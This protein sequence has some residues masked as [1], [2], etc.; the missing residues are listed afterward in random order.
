MA[1]FNRNQVGENGLAKIAEDLSLVRLKSTD[2]IGSI[3]QIEGLQDAL[4]GK[5][6]STHTHKYAG[7]ASAGG[8]ATS[9]NKV[10][11]SLKIQ[12]NGG[13]TEN[14][15]LFT[16]NGSVAKTVNI[17]ASKIGAAASSH[18]HNVATTSKA[19]FLSASDKSKLDSLTI[20]GDTSGYVSKS[21]DQ[22]YGPLLFKDTHYY[23]RGHFEGIG[24]GSFATSAASTS[25]YAA[26]GLSNFNQNTSL[27]LRF[28]G[29]NHNNP[30]VRIDFTVG[31]YCK[32]QWEHSLYLL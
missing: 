29:Y 27:S 25:F 6:A 4:D 26:I 30:R 11:N 1:D 7:S 12:L 17:T 14:T 23:N 19:G 3:A 20:Q 2:T 18:T 31:S 21:G 9:A 32:N 10:N 16:F 28:N 13:T 5:A 22:M 15:N 24:S 8:A